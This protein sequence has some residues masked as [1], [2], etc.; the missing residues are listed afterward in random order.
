MKLT[1]TVVD[2]LKPLMDKPQVLYRDEQLKG[3]AL[4]ITANGAKSFVV[5]K[6]IER[7][8][9]RLTIGRYGE[10]TCEQAR[11]EAQKLLGKIASG[12]NPLAERLEAKLKAVTLDAVFEEYLK[13]RK[14]LKAKTLYDYRRV[15]DIAFGDWRGKP[16]LSITKDMV[17]RRHAMLGETRGAAYANLSMRV[18]RAIF[19]FA[20]GRYEDPQGGSLVTDNPVKRLSQTR[21]WYRV[22]RRQTV[23]K[24]HELSSWYQA[25]VALENETVRDCLL[26][27]L[28][29]GL[30]RQEAAKLMWDRVDL[31]GRS[32][33]VLDTKNSEPHTLPLSHF[34][35]DMLGARKNKA[36]G[37]YVFPGA[38][39]S[40]Y[41]T[42][43]RVQIAKVVKQGGVSFTVHDLRRTFTTAAESLDISTLTVK[44]LLNHKL[45]DVTA[46][47]AVIDVEQLR[48]PMQSITDYLLRC[49]GVREGGQVIALARE[50]A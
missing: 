31:K 30:R 34:L 42:E 1:K 11:R 8:V 43:P 5:E 40:G 37:D 24:P 14:D 33:T 13:A 2:K 41:I 32:L 4:R 45:S 21:A 49:A 10:L 39:Q 18:L 28:L 12:V 3:F 6:L 25:V 17:A 22:A 20:A 46:G 38:S 19:N 7:K 48:R 26:L 27:V 50:E 44:R 15:I 35:Y 23:I 47:Y 9:R 36:T 16:L 29:T